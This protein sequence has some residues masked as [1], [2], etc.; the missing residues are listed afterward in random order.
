MDK[1]LIIKVIVAEDE[2][3]IRN[4]L[5]KKIESIDP[6]FQ[7]VADADNG[8]K[9]M[10]LIH[11]HQPDLV[12]TDIRMAMMDGIE[13]ITSVNLS[14]SHTRKI[15]ISGYADFD[16]ARQAMRHGVDEYLLKPVS[17]EELK[18]CLSK[19]KV[20]ITHDKLLFKENMEG[21]QYSD[22]NPEEIVQ[23]V[24]SYLKENFTKDLSLEK[25]AKNFNFNSSYLSKIFNKH[26]G[27]L[28]SKYL[29]SLRINEAKYLLTHFKNLSIKEVGEM[30]GY[31]DQFYFSRVFKQ[32]TGS[33]PK[34]FQK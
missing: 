8:K 11:I 13:L 14:Y 15:I 7:V 17:T 10:E 23:M 12:M 22:T 4:N 24:Q 27:E 6:A 3:L 20:S 5:V 16:Y 30:V 21:I 9:A 25:I 18:K 34:D 1:P 31:P 33:T 2:D 29:M 32:V 19:I 26:T 28:P